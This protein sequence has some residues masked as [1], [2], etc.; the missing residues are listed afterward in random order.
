[1]DGLRNPNRSRRVSELGFAVWSFLGVPIIYFLYSDLSY[2]YALSQG[3]MPFTGEREWLIY[4][5]LAICLSTGGFCLGKISIFR[6]HIVV[7]ELTYFIAMGVILLVIYIAVAFGHG[8][9]L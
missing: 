6:R 4:F 9:S 2:R 5:S 3:K 7:S 1:M 8:N